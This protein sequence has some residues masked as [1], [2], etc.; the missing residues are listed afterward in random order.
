MKYGFGFRW[1]FLGP[2]TTSDFGGVDTFYRIASYLLKELSTMQEPP[3]MMKELFESGAMGVKAGKGW[4][5]YSNGRDVMMTKYRDE[6]FV[7]HA[8]MLLEMD[9]KYGF[10]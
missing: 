6:C 3:Q 7:K 9:K 1:A 8:D 4:Y 5:D 2:F 10:R